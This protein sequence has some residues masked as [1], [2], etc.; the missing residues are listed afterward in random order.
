MILE[1]KKEYILN[2]LGNSNIVKVSDL[3]KELHCTE[4]S[5]RYIVNDLAKK[6]LLI[7]IHGGIKK[8]DKIIGDVSIKILEEQNVDKKEHIANIAIGFIKDNSTII[9]DSGTTNLIFAR[10]IKGLFKNL[11][12]ITNSIQIAGALIDDPA[13]NL[14]ILGG[15]IRPLTYSI[16]NYGNESSLKNLKADIL[17]LNIGAVS[18]INGLTD[19]NLQEARVKRDMV[20]AS[21]KVILLADSSKFGKTAISLVCSLNKLDKIITD[22][23]ISTKFINGFKKL[24]L[25]IIY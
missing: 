25:D 1:E 21:N 4:A 19:P 20:E 16:V 24:N 22:T 15:I 9:L 11:N 18:L 7:R 5:I 17:F 6:N 2:K 13:I 23:E 14:I 10:K 12:I 3:S 8:E